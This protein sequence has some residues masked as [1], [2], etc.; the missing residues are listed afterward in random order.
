[1]N[2]TKK[3]KG[4]KKLIIAGICL[5]MCMAL[6]FLTGNIPQI[7]SALSPMHFPVLLC[8]FLSGPYYA[9]MIG[10]VSPLLRFALFGMPP[11]FPTGVS[12]CF[13]LAAY[14]LVS[15]LLYKL[16]PKKASHIY[17][18]L[19]AAMLTGRIVWGVVRVLLSGVSGSPF[20][21]EIFLSGAVLKAIPGIVLQIVLIPGIVYAL[22][23]TRALGTEDDA[24]KSI[25]ALDARL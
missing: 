7:G 15:G 21:W 6:P 8:G 19:I 10:F 4:L 16:L 17:T 3:N 25:T 22:Q 23:K 9:A 20:T 1:M 11:I 5:G 14:G 18:S 13:E 24:K 12:M 2:E